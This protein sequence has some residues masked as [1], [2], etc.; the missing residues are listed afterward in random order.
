[1]TKG[2]QKFEKHLLLKSVTELSN[3]WICSI[4]T[5]RVFPSDPSPTLDTENYTFTKG[6][7][8]QS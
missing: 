8:W 4:L 7:R 6:G 2:R 1:M 5:W 3:N